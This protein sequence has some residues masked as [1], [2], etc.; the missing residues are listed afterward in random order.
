MGLE[1]VGMFLIFFL[2]FFVPQ[3][4][5]LLG[6]SMLWLYGIADWATTP[7]DLWLAPLR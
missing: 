4:Q 6:Q 1:R 2:I 7:I 3:F 5:R